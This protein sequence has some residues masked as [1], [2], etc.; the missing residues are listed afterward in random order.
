MDLSAIELRQIAEQRYPNLSSDEA[1][2]RLHRDFFE[3]VRQ[4]AGPILQEHP[5]ILIGM[6]GLIGSRWLVFLGMMSK[7]GQA[8]ASRF[9][10]STLENPNANDSPTVE[11]I[12]N[13]HTQHLK[14]IQTL[15]KNYRRPDILGQ[16][17]AFSTF[18]AAVA[19]IKRLADHTDRMATSLSGIE[20]NIKSLNVRGDHFPQNIHSYVRSMI[21]THSSDTVSH[22]FTVFSKG[23]LW[24]P[25]FADLQRSDPLGPSYLGQRTDLD[26]LC[27]FLA[28]EVRPRVGPQAILHILMPTIGQIS[29]EEAVKFPEAMHPCS[30]NG[31][32]GDAGTPFV[33]ICT[34]ERRDKECLRD[35]GVLKQREIWVMFE[36][37]G[38]PFFPAIYKRVRYFVDPTYRVPTEV[39]LILGGSTY[40]FCGLE[41]PRTL[42]QRAER[43]WA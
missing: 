24:Y 34:P 39:G 15:L 37:I 17:V 31:E 26:E 3:Q 21:E 7:I 1:F 18:G 9:S 28:E 40:S 11:I 33:Y 20:E 36:A 23:N 16:L 19:Q 41:P 6:G 27:A 32:L 12:N 35:I 38:I 8:V 5:E 14:N 4:I 29:L 42:G 13:I 30:I 25:K 43:P 22:Y 10:Q 2:L